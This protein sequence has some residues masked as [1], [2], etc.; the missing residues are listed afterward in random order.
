M[1]ALILAAGLG[2]R[3][4]PYTNKIPKKLWFLSRVPKL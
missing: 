1:E 3:L 4:R 2:S